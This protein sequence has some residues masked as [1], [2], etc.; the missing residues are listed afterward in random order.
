MHTPE[1]RV[2]EKS[3]HPIEIT[4]SSADKIIDVADFSLDRLD[5][6]KYTYLMHQTDQI[7]AKGIAQVGLQHKGALTSTTYFAGK[8]SLPQTVEK[9]KAGE[10]HRGS[11]SLVILAFPKD[12]F[13]ITPR[14]TQSASDQIEEHLQLMGYPH[15]VPAEY[16]KNIIM[17]PS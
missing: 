13:P 2:E 15:S 5:F 6:D 1:S 4:S 8:I 7:S 17:F 11:D 12:Q 14:G 9:M 16:V 3:D 10:R